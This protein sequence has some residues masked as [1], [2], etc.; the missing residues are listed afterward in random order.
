M[1]YQGINQPK[2]AAPCGVYREHIGLNEGTGSATKYN[3][4]SPQQ[5]TDDYRTNST[6]DWTPS[7]YSVDGVVGHIGPAGTT[8]SHTR[9]TQD[10][11]TGL[12][13]ASLIRSDNWDEHLRGKRGVDTDTISNNT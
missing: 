2:P 8:T 1:A 11:G 13:A 5:V 6:I 4:P 3:P 9:D 12:V 10:Y 7:D